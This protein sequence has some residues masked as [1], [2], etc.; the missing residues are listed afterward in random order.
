MNTEQHIFSDAEVETEHAIG[1]FA[2]WTVE[3]IKSFS[4][5]FAEC[6]SRSNLPAPFV[7]WMKAELLHEAKRRGSEG[8][9]E[10]KLLC[11][12]MHVLSSTERE[13]ILCFLE[14][15]TFP[16][17]M[18]SDSQKEF[19]NQL[20]FQLIKS[21]ILASRRIDRVLTKRQIAEWLGIDDSQVMKLVK[22][23]KLP[24]PMFISPR[25]PRWLESAVYAALQD[26]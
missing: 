22:V 24:Q 2:S 14:A 16:G 26:R 20:R 10:P 5:I 23:G 6:V 17:R 1:N 11:V 7:A 25:H 4:R 12:P 3:D 18:F 19:L 21:F 9:I 13:T 15:I 8:R